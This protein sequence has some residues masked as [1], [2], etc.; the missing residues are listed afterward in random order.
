MRH[1]IFLIMLLALSAVAAQAQVKTDWEDDFDNLGQLE[2]VESEGWE[3]TYD[4]LSDLQTAPVDLNSCTRE[5]LERFPFLSQQQVMDILEYRNRYR[6][7][8][9]EN[10][11]KMI[12]SLDWHT[13]QLLT[14]FVRIGREP[15][16]DSV[17]LLRSLLRNGRSEV[18]G[19]FKWPLYDRHGDRNGYL[20]YKYKHW[21]RYSFTSGQRLKA[22]LL[23]SQDAGEPF[24]S[25]QNQ[26]GYDFY[27]FYF[28]MRDIRRLKALALGRYRLRFGMGLALNNSF[29]LGKLATLSSLG[30]SDN[31]I[32]AH[33]SRSEANYLQGAAATVILLKG[34]DLTAFVS[35]RKIDATLTDSG[36]AV[37][38]ILTS[39]Y[40]RTESEMK[41]RRNVSQTLAGGNVNYA[42]NGFHVGVTAFATSLDK[43]LRPDT[44]QAYRRWYPEGKNFWNASI[45]YGYLSNRL[46][47]QGETATGDCHSVATINTVSYQTD[48]GLSAMLLQR[49]Y[50]YQYH[51]LFGN[52]FAAGGA[53]R[54]ESGVYLGLSYSA[55]RHWKMM[56]YTDFAYFPQA[57]Y[58]AAAGSHCWDNMLTVNYARGPW[59]L[60]ARYRLKLQ[61]RNDSTRTSLVYKAEHRGRLSAEYT[62]GPF[63]LKTQAD[64]AF[65]SFEGTSFGWMVAQ[66]GGVSCRRLKAYATLGYFHT[67]DYNS[68]VYTYERGILY[69]FSFPS[70]YG[71]GI[72]YALC[73]S[74][75]P[76]P[77]LMLVAKAGTTDYF[78]RNHISSGL[79]QIDRSA[80]T[81]LEIQVRW[82]F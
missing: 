18:V 47:F 78:D 33:S 60:A 53:V 16:S 19:A 77:S 20:G 62:R 72:R 1:L 28:L 70:F 48:F 23:A 7:I 24:F 46:T 55:R 68:R 22:G 15:T 11:L 5:D 41:R 34:L 4:E 42:C 21:L 79:Q 36:Q 73:L 81:D 31:H 17:P 51:S 12:P 52:S 27:S 57:R 26:W 40:H 82:R 14:H 10:E 44:R 9:T 30:R 65:C 74:A 8:E 54:N 39:G 80:M 43:P 2:D 3:Q 38:T 63:W 6:R 35:W 29:S 67:D 25:G 58:Q 56:F 45:D 71:E 64:A 37:R 76:L 66:S 75:S 69:N 49:Y 59:T 13:Q 50:A 32:F 61:Q